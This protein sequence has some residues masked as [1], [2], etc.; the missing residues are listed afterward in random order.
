[1]ALQVGDKVRFMDVT[2]GGVITRIEGRLAFVDDEDGFETPVLI[3]DLV[4]VEKQGRSDDESVVTTDSG[5]V[6]SIS[7]EVEDDFEEDDSEGEEDPGVIL[8]F[9]QG[10]KQGVQSGSVRMHLINDSNYF[11]FFA[12]NEIGGNNQAINI[13]NGSLVPNTKMELGKQLVTELDG[14]R[15][16]VQVRYLMKNHHY[17]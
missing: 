14:K 6:D 2:G 12:I 1:M 15:F 4:I 5:D 9:L 10:D 3:S 13:Y 7:D 16:D 11:C 17:P 8:A